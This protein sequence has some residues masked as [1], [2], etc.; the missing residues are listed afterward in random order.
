MELNLVSII[1]LNILLVFCKLSHQHIEINIGKRN[2]FFS[3]IKKI[4]FEF[5]LI[6]KRA[7]AFDA[8]G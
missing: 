4:T 6:S 1:I 5:V 7:M 2:K 8:V 3:Y